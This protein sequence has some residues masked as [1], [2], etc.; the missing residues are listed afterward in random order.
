MD[1]GAF[2][3]RFEEAAAACREFAQEFVEERLPSEIRFRLR[4]N[5]S[6]DANQLHADEVV[7]PDDGGAERARELRSCAGQT[8]VETLFREGRVPEQRRRLA[9]ADVRGEEVVHDD[10][11]DI[12]ERR[13]ELQDLLAILNVG[14]ARSP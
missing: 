9:V 11:R 7:Y 12:G 10:A 3:Q 5:S 14:L 6:Y 4:L 1:R 13:N 8:V 2:A